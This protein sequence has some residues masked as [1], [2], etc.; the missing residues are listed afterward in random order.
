MVFFLAPRR[1]EVRRL[2]VLLLL[3]TRLRSLA[4]GFLPRFP[5]YHSALAPEFDS[6]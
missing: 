5:R 6:L 3:L 1:V 4:L 2:S